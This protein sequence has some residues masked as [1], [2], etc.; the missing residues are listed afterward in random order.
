MS[1]PVPYSIYTV[2]HILAFGVKPIICSRHLQE[3][4]FVNHRT[5]TTQ[6]SGFYCRCSGST[7][8]RF[9]LHFCTTACKL[10]PPCFIAELVSQPRFPK[11]LKLWNKTRI[12]RLTVLWPLIYKIRTIQNHW[13]RPWLWLIITECDQSLKIHNWLYDRWLTNYWLFFLRVDNSWHSE[14]RHFTV[15]WPSRHLHLTGSWPSLHRYL[16]IWWPSLHCYLTIWWPSLHRYLTIWW[17]SR[18]CHLTLWWPSPHRHLTISWPTH[19]R[20]LTISW[21]SSQDD[22]RENLSCILHTLTWKIC[23]KTYIPWCYIIRAMEIQIHCTWITH[24]SL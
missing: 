14:G 8:R 6:A 24:Q 9:Y 16:T 15:W 4:R 20:H 5:L 13:W 12:I 23:V 3:S 21:P 7:L 2:R 1:F 10:H 17:P 22:E 19:H 11:Y 18:Y